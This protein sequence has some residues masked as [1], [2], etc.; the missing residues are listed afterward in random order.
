MSAQVQEPASPP[1]PG[2]APLFKVVSHSNLFYWWPVWVLGFILSGLSFIDENR[3]AIVPRGT[4]VTEAKDANGK[5]T[6]TLTVPAKPT[7]LLKQA[8]DHTRDGKE[9]F[10]YHISQSKALGVVASF[11]VLIVILATTV[12]LRGLWSVVNLMA[13]VLL[14]ILFAFLSW[15]GPIL[16]A[17]GR[18]HIYTNAAGYFFPSVALFLFWLITVFL[19]DQRR[20]IIFSPGQIIVHREVGDQQQVY[21]TGGVAVEKRLN[22]FVRHRLLGLGAGD[23]VVTTGDGRHEFELPNVLFADSKVHQIAEVMKMR[24]VTVE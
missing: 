23:L 24:P 16:E 5:E 9:A 17:L 4:T 19:F 15:W 8:A 14:T 10:P 18:L 7:E 12:T 2:Q 11:V 3:L 13:L 21:D 22:D 20:F 6:F 1:L